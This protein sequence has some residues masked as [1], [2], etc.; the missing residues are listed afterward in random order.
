MCLHHPPCLKSCACPTDSCPQVDSEQGRLP[1]RKQHLEKFESP[2]PDGEGSNS[3]IVGSGYP[4][5]RWG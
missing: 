5:S 3:F 1:Q 2:G 4:Q